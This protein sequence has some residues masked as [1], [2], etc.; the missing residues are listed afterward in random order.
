MTCLVWHSVVVQHQRNIESVIGIYVRARTLLHK[1]KN[2][3]NT[4]EGSHRHTCSSF[5]DVPQNRKITSLTRNSSPEIVL[6]LDLERDED[7]V[8][9]NG[10]AYIFFSR[11]FISSNPRKQQIPCLAQ[12]PFPW[13][14]CEDRDLTPHLHFLGKLTVCGFFLLQQRISRY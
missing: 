8:E 4:T 10:S 14:L 7:C 12:V 13:T 9:V 11:Q 5:T 1:Y 3:N 6:A 2:S